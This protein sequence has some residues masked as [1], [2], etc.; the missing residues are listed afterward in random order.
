M[1]LLHRVELHHSWHH[2]QSSAAEMTQAC[3][4][5]QM[6]PL[7]T[8]RDDTFSN[9]GRVSAVNTGCHYVVCNVG[10]SDLGKPNNL[11]FTMVAYNLF[12]M[13]LSIRG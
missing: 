2:Q 4:T 5:L 1:L 9:D 10:L 13:S 8:L 3:M 11:N 7:F 12:I 6:N